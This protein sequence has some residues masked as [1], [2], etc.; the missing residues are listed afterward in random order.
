MSFARIKP[1]SIRARLT[2]LYLG[3]M[4]FTLTVFCTVLYQVFVRNHQQEFDFALY[5]HA[6]DVAQS[7]NVDYYGDFSFTPNALLAKEKVFPFSLGKSFVQV[8]SL[9]G[10]FLGG[11]RLPLYT[12]DWQ[13]AFRKGVSYRTLNSSDLQELR[14]TGPGEKYRQ[15]TY[16]VR[17]GANPISLLQIAVP[18]EML[19]RE[20]KYLLLFFFIGIPTT[21]VLAGVAGLYLANLALE[22]IREIVQKAKKLNPSNLSERLPEPDTEDE[23][24]R[25]TVTLNELLGR[26]ERAFQS[27]ENFIA[28]A[29]HQLKTPLAIVRGELDV[30]RSKERGPEEV[31]A[32]IDSAGQ[33]LLH[34]SRLLD[35]LL[36]LTKIDAGAGSFTVRDVR[37]DE[38]LLEAT[39]RFEVLAQKKNISIRFNLEDRTEGDSKDDFVVQGDSDL[40][41]SMFRNLVDNAIKYSPEGTHV[42]VRVINEADRVVTLIKDQGEAIPPELA[43]RI[44]RRHER[45]NLLMSG[46][47][48]AGLGLTIAKRIAELHNGNISILQD[49]SPGKSFQV[50]MKKN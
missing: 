46:A 7:I 41:Q 21:L 1:A 5:N 2:V 14:R 42:E 20:S 30:F 15:I 31:R 44:F 35:D 4:A 48:G 11:N 40:L 26:I 16:L 25:L 22:P 8:L 47:S 29:S 34:M 9:D 38:V 36:L 6:V 33:E 28:D 49:N 10:R 13:T 19:E 3:L 12:E 27:H 50:E 37:L 17:N 23:V 18:T 24:K 39:A 32:F 43:E 45:G